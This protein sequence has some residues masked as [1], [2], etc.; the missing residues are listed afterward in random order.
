MRVVGEGVE[1]LLARGAVIAGFETEIAVRCRDGTVRSDRGGGVENRGAS[2]VQVSWSATA[3]LRD[4]WRW[5]IVRAIVHAR[6]NS[7]P[8]KNPGIRRFS[9]RQ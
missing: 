8:V 4:V 2:D 6:G 9:M 1:S 7:S 5:H 3:I